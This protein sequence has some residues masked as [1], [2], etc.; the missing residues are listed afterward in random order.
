M[1]DF[2]I[3]WQ[4]FFFFFF[5][6]CGGVWGGGGGGACFAVKLISVLI[7]IE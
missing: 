7:G 1:H 2:E 6:V 5:C 3:I 4:S